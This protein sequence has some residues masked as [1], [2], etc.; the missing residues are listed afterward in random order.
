MKAEMPLGRFGRPGQVANLV[1]FLA[2]KRA[3]LMLGA[4]VAA[5]GPPVAVAN[6]S[7]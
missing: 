2:S 6:L 7:R 5:D 1:V 4:C 3:S